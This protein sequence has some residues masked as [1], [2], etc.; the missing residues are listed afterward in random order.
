MNL[1][2]ILFSVDLGSQGLLLYLKRLTKILC[3]SHIRQIA[4]LH[5]YEMYRAALIDGIVQASDSRILL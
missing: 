4:S 2:A 3:R 1:L 5:W